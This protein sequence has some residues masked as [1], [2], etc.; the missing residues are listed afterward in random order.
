M[1][2]LARLIIVYSLCFV[3]SCLLSMLFRFVGFWIDS[4]RLISPGFE[5][6]E[7]LIDS[8][9]MALPMTLFL[10]ILLSLSYSIRR[11]IPAFF[12]IL[13]VIILSGAFTLGFFMAIEKIQTLALFFETSNEA[14]N[15]FSENPRS[16]EGLI[17]SRQ[18][19]SVI[20]L[21][22]GDASNRNSLG[23]SDFPRVVSF[24]ERP[25]I[26]QETAL[27][28]NNSIPAL[29]FADRTPWLVRSILMDFTI[30]ARE[31]HTR[32]QKGLI[33]LG[34]Y[35]LSLIF[36][37]ASLRFILDL[38]SWHLANLFMG[39]LVFRLVLSLEIFLNAPETLVLLNIFLNNRFPDFLIAPAIFCILGSLIL[40][41]T[42]LAFIVRR[43][44]ARR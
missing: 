17:V 24:P 21:S 5:Q 37:L 16:K 12:S 15:K 27:G 36:I 3:I 30:T 35:A 28:P 20:L 11:K 43:K 26:Y 14:S 2:N 10:T 22:K 42:Y 39:A 6:G 7:L 40:V 31:F 41:Y 44:R 38:C 1:K 29:P 32:Y 25:L 23:L 13:L 8:A 9:R 34:I 19:M 33:F 4:I 18:D